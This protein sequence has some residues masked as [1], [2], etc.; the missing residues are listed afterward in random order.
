MPDSVEI[1][2]GQQQHRIAAGKTPAEVLDEF[3]PEWL[4]RGI[5]V[6]LNG[7]VFDFHTPLRRDGE[8]LL[9]DPT[10]DPEKALE[11]CRHTSSHVLAQAVKQL[12]DDVMVGIGPPTRE[13][14]YYDF[15]R[16]EPFT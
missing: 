5:A 9:V 2:I 14:F 12:Y 8:L 11:I 6:R 7:A 4:E 10:G 1:K 13:G 3:A 15:L 16:P